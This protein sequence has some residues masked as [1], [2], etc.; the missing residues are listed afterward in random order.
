MV[1]EI[2]G[3]GG[4]QYHPQ[5]KRV[6]VRSNGAGHASAGVVAP[7]AVPPKPALASKDTVS[8]KSAPVAVKPQR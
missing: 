3:A 7:G 8:I 1:R 6:S 2:G 5:I 4:G